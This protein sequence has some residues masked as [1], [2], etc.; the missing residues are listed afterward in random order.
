MPLPEFKKKTETFYSIESEKIYQSL[1]HDYEGGCF[2]F[3]SFN[4][5]VD[6]NIIHITRKYDT[7][8]NIVKEIGSFKAGAIFVVSLLTSWYTTYSRD[9]VLAN[10]LFYEN[11]SK[12]E[13]DRPINE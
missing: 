2:K 5:F 6:E 1:C 10:A 11:I 12:P 4:I 9:K 7:V 13:K 8:M 3:S